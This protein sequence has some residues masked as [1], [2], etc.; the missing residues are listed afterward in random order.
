MEPEHSDDRD[1]AVQEVAD[2]LLRGAGMT[3][4]P[5]GPATRSHVMKVVGCAGEV[6][7]AGMAKARELHSAEPST[8]ESS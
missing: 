8:E 1:R 2:Y 4:M 3:L 6:G 7:E 5:E